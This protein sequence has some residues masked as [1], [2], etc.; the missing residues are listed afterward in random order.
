MIVEPAHWLLLVVSSA[1]YLIGGM[2]GLAVGVMLLSVC[3]MLVHAS[4]R[5]N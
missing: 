1:G 2:N 5:D 3:A 4:D